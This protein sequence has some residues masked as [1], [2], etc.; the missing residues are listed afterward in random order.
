LTISA[1]AL[2]M[3]WGG[4]ALAQATSAPVTMQPIPNPPEAAKMHSAKHH[5]K[6]HAKAAKAADATTDSAAPASK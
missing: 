1:T 6:H 4:S 5:A 2:A 3:A